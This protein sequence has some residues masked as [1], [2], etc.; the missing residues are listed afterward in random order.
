MAYKG[1][2]FDLDGT[3]LDSMHVWDDFALSYLQEKG[4]E[5]QVPLDE[6]FATLRMEEAIAFLHEHVVKEETLENIEA[7]IYDLLVKRYEHVALKTGVKECINSLWDHGIQM[8]VLSAN[9]PV[10]CNAALAKHELFDRFSCILSCEDIHM[11]KTDPACYRYASD[12]MKLKVEDCI[13]VE[14]AL[15]AIQGAK[16]AGFY[17][18]GVKEESQ[19]KDWEEIERCADRVI[20]E[21]KELEEIICRKL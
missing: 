20:T 19:K 4:I 10:I 11:S 14:D 21:M 3:L 9:H 5:P 16:K 12:E 6:L 1:C 18:V 13:V 15:H 2:I 17:V 8:S 7:D